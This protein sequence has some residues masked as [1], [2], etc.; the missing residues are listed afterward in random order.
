ML[1]D[2]LYKVW[3]NVPCLNISGHNL[4]HTHRSTPKLQIFLH[5]VEGV[6]KFRTFRFRC[7]NNQ[8]YLNLGSRIINTQINA[9]WNSGSGKNYCK[10]MYAKQKKIRM[11]FHSFP[12]VPLIPVRQD[13]FK[14]VP[15]IPAQVTITK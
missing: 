5:K 3:G 10:I 4:E 11:R 13:S 14:S 7:S 1:G 12:S 8:P 15:L 9:T 6:Q 2:L